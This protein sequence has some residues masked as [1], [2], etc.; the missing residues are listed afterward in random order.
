MNINYLS[1]LKSGVENW[2]QWRKENPE[3]TP[4]LSKAYLQGADLQEANLREVNFYGA[5]LQEANL[6]GVNLKGVNLQEADELDEI[7]EEID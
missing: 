6:R 7:Y 5:Y 4:D 2:N 1:I 3:I